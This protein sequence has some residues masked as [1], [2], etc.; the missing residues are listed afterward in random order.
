[1]RYIPEHTIYR[2]L[3]ELVKRNLNINVMHVHWRKKLRLVDCIGHATWGTPDIYIQRFLN[4]DTTCRVIAHEARHIWQDQI[5]PFGTWEND[6]YVV[7]GVKYT[8][9]EVNSGR[10]DLPW[11]IDAIKYEE[12]IM[13]YHRRTI[14]RCRLLYER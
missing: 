11:E 8:T 4:F 9:K 1:M 3:I 10:E 13:R 2:D 7:N 5:V 6:L 14:D 12:Y